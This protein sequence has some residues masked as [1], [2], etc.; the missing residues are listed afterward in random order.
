[1][2]RGKEREG[3]RGRKKE[4][5]RAREGKDAQVRNGTMLGG[6]I[7]KWMKYQTGKRTARKRRR[8]DEGTRDS[9]ARKKPEHGREGSTTDQL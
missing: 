1:M 8:E 2:R 3:R 7:A 5:L 6:I 4:W 9:H